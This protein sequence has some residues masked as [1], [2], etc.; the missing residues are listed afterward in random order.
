MTFLVCDSCGS[1]YE[2]QDGESAQ[3][4]ECICGG[5]LRCTDSIYG[6]SPKKSIRE[7]FN[8]QSFPVKIALISLFAILIILFCYL[9]FSIAF[10]HYDGPAYSFDYPTGWVIDS[11][12]GDLITATKG[13]GNK[14][15]VMRVSDTQIYYLMVNSLSGSWDQQQ[16]TLDGVSAYEFSKFSYGADTIYIWFVKDNSAYCVTFSGNKDDINEFCDEFVNSFHVK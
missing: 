12:Y 16:I 8:K 7:Q 9:T 5:K 11:T 15:S 4:Y 1:R 13:P 3:D 14:F 10:P 2:I 6:D